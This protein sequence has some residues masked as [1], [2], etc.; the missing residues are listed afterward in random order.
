MLLGSAVQNE[1]ASHE[2]EIAGKG[3][4]G[5]VP[6]SV[7]R[8]DVGAHSSRPCSCARL[9][10]PLFSCARA[11]AQ[12]PMHE[13][14]VYGGLTSRLHPLSSPPQSGKQGMVLQSRKLTHQQRRQRRKLTR[15]DGPG[16]QVLPL[17]QER[18]SREFRPWE[19]QTKPHPL[20]L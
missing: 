2:R 14:P 19:G 1:A 18:V 17:E 15:Q 9:L 7:Q 5:I 4:Q 3:L 10:A 20:Q 8:W 16:Q 11:R 13:P 6:K 12:A